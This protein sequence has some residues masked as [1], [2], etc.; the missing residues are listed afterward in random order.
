MAYP[1]NLPSLAPTSFVVQVV[2]QG[3]GRS[4]GVLEVGVQYLLRVDMGKK[5]GVKKG[6][7]GGDKMILEKA[8]DSDDDQLGRGKAWTDPMDEEDDRERRDLAKRMDRGRRKGAGWREEGVVL[9]ISDSDS[10]PELEVRKRMKAEKKAAKKKRRQHEDE[11]G[12]ASD[13]ED[14][15]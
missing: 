4:G 15:G 7:G 8:V 12:F 11:E 3:Q 10:D 5:K 2:I 6:G 14:E 9:A 13:L 1:L